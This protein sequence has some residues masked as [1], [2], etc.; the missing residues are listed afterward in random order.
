[1]QLHCL[2][3]LLKHMITKK[4]TLPVYPGRPTQ[5]A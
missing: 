2:P 4:W 3:V 5:I 1:M